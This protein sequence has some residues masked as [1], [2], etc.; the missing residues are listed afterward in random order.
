MICGH[1]KAPFRHVRKLLAHWRETGCPWGRPVWERVR[2]S[3]R[4]G[5]SG[6]R[7]LHN[8][9]PTLWPSEPMPE[10]VKERLQNA[11]P[12]AN[13]PKTRRNRPSAVTIRRGRYPRRGSGISGRDRVVAQ[14]VALLL[15]APSALL[16]LQRLQEV[17]L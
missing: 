11:L 10:E 5:H 2:E 1:C 8:R 12:R 13:G 4:A 9:W 6:R 14:G 16:V 15:L 3:R 7:I 17:L